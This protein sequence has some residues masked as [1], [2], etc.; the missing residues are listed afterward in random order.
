MKIYYF[1]AIEKVR[2]T[3]F[4]S[5]NKKLG[6]S[7]SRQTFSRLP[8]SYR[9]FLQTQKRDFFFWTTSISEA[10]NPSIIP[11]SP[12]SWI[13]VLHSPSD[14]LFNTRSATPRKA[15]RF[16]RNKTHHSQKLVWFCKTGSMFPGINRPFSSS[17][18]SYLTTSVTQSEHFSHLKSA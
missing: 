14:S 12:L 1:C 13:R 11:W 7:H 10:Q 18:N 2:R 5:L 8:R 6:V 17:K 3:N 9:T 15:D 16:P 4:S